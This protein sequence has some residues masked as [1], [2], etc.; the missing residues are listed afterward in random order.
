MGDMRRKPTIADVAAMA[1][2]SKA[3]VSRVLNLSERVLPTT[4][5]TVEEAMAALGYQESWQA[6]SLATGR[7]GAIGV[8]LT[9]PF[10][11]IYSD[12]TFATQLRGIYDRLA[13]TEIV[14]LLLQ[15]SSER[16]HSKTIGLLRRG[17]ADA[18]I[19]LTPYVDDGLLPGLVQ[20][21]IPTVVTGRPPE[22]GLAGRLSAVFSDDTAGAVLAAE[23]AAERGR[24]DPLVVMGPVDNP[25]SVERVNG[26]RRVFPGIDEVDVLHGPWDTISGRARVAEALRRDLRFDVVLAGSDRIALGAL[27]AL[28]SHG[29]RVPEDVA[30]IG[31]DNH[32]LA[33]TTSPALTTVDQ[34]LRAEGEM[35]AELALERLAG[36][37]PRVHEMPM[38]LVVRESA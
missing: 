7:A 23:Y 37:A 15:A 4:R 34:P 29:R 14:P 20:E 24:R 17:A 16:E 3:T 26:Y 8:L 12:P 19:H 9:E 22:G 1:G 36:A 28:A 18:V 2:V 30:V 35:A 21:G 11:D 31:F 32:P 10:D 27:D 25:A 38:N 13:T 33:A 5:A 6:K